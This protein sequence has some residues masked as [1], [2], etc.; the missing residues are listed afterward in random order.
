MEQVKKKMAALKK[1]ADDAE[2]RAH[3]A[4]EALRVSQAT[5]ERV[6]VKY[7]DTTSW[8]SEYWKA[9]IIIALL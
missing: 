9:S 2:G 6:R 3:E 8:E 7:M 5:A 4:E 1:A